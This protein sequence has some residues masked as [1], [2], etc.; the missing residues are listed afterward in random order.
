MTLMLSMNLGF[1]W[2]ILNAIDG[3]Y[4]VTGAQ[5]FRAGSVQGDAWQAGAVAA[6]GRAAGSVQG[7][8]NG[9]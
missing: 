7:Q 4:V 1:A 9:Q 8:E 2:G 6:Q 3:P 5:P